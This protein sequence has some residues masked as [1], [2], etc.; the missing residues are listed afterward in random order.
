MP[1]GRRGERRSG[2]GA[3]EERPQRGRQAGL[4]TRLHQEPGVLRHRERDRA[5]RG[6]HDRQAAGERLGQRHP[7]PLVVGGE[8]EERRRVVQRPEPVGRALAREADPV[9]QPE[10]G[11]GL[12]HA[13][14]VAGIALQ[15][16][17]AHAA[18][19]QVADLREGSHQHVVA[20]AGRDGRDAQQRRWLARAGAA[21]GRRGPGPGRDHPDA[22]G[23]HRVPLR[24]S[25]GGVPARHDD[26]GAG[27][28]RPPLRGPEAGGL[29]IAEPRLVG[30]RVVDQGEDPQALSVPLREVREPT[31]RQ[32]VDHHRRPGP[33]SAERGVQRRPGRGVR[34]RK[35]AG[36]VV[37]GDRAPEVAEPGHDPGVVDVAAGPLLE[38]T[39][40]DDVHRGVGH[41]LPS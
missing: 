26:S 22:V 16:A 30:E 18:P 23:G 33:D 20:L 5:P 12:P 28:E 2:R 17:H 3:A 10:L 13:P 24:E 32:A 19:L 27:G 6:A 25:A 34:V 11:D 37:D 7:V 39:G 38:E 8:H 9:R 15:A 36:E 4:V 21:G 29:R 14:R 40:H 1:T 41:G 35:A 31:Q